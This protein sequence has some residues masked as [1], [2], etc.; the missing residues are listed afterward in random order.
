MRIGSVQVPPGYVAIAAGVGVVNAGVTFAGWGQKPK[1]ASEKVGTAI[2]HGAILG[3]TTVISRGPIMRTL[4]LGALVGDV[5]GNLASAGIRGDD[6][7]AP[8][9]RPGNAW[10]DITGEITREVKDGVGTAALVGGGVG[11]L[12]GIVGARA[13]KV[14]WP[15]SL[16][17]G[18]TMAGAGA[19][20]A[21][22]SSIG[23]GVFRGIYDGTGIAIGRGIDAMK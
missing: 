15:G 13:L 19:G 14:G 2:S 4:A 18:A 20:L 1:S 10:T 17:A 7:R 6:A 5:A 16:I 11:G 8:K 3:A 22:A 21:G 23:A 9:P 12:V